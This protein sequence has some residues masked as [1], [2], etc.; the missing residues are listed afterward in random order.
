MHEASLSPLLL[1]LGWKKNG[2]KD[3][4]V[5]QRKISFQISQVIVFKSSTSCFSDSVLRCLQRANI[6]LSWVRIRI[7]ESS[8]QAASWTCWLDYYNKKESAWQSVLSIRILLSFFH[9]ERPCTETVPCIDVLEVQCSQ[10]QTTRLFLFSHHPMQLVLG[11]LGCSVGMEQAFTTHLNFQV[12][13]LMSVVSGFLPP[14][15]NG[16]CLRLSRASLLGHPQ[17]LLLLPPNTHVQLL[18]ECLTPPK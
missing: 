16:C 15:C 5:L 1:E 18:S 17:E 10:P 7:S 13:L 8:E 12:S 11:G 4:P 14:G 9:F 2:W 6:A 3:V